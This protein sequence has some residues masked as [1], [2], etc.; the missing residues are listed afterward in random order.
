MKLGPNQIVACPHCGVQAFY[1]P[2][3]SGN[4]FGAVTW[5]DGQQHAPMLKMPPHVVKCHAC[6][7]CFW[8]AAATEVDADGHSSTPELRE[9]TA[10]EYLAALAAGFAKTAEQERL[11]RILAWWR[12]NDHA[13]DWPF[14]N[15]NTPSPPATL[16]RQNLV[17]LADLLDEDNDNDRLMR[18]EVLRELGDFAAAKQALREVSADLGWVADQIRR[19]CAATDTR[20]HKLDPGGSRRPRQ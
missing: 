9:P 3:L 1:R 18:A 5:T 15:E 16:V 13:R 6:P 20:V 11:V 2:L 19:Y 7:A 14:V 12:W 4:T 17:R 10:A 8:L